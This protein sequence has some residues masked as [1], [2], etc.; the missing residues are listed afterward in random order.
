MRL[1]AL[2]FEPHLQETADQLVSER[3]LRPGSYLFIYFFVG[4]FFHPVGSFLVYFPPYCHSP[5]TAAMFYP[6]IPSTP[7]PKLHV[8]RHSSIFPC[9]T[10]AFTHASLL[11]PLLPSIHTCASILHHEIHLPYLKPLFYILATTQP[12]PF[13]RLPFTFTH[14]SSA[15]SSLHL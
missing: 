9:H 4:S 10:P 8:T 1:K 14:Q 3:S 7:N 5:L 15:F 2:F 13:T 12:A 11:L 6:D